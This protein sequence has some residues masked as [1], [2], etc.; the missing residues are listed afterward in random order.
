M[1]WGG[2]KIGRECENVWL[3]LG[4]VWL[5]SGHDRI[6]R[7]DFMLGDLNMVE[8]ALE[9]L[10]SRQ[11]PIPI[12]EAFDNLKVS[13]QLEDGWQNTFPTRLEYTYKQE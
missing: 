12:L 2:A 6:Q 4:L 5:R 11:D 10:P 8:E 3:V 9:Q 1:S 7:P 13:L